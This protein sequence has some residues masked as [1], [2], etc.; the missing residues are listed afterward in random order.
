VIVEFMDDQ[1]D[2]FGVEP[3]CTVLQM[4]PSYYAAK[5]RPVRTSRSSPNGSVTPLRRSRSTCTRMCRPDS[6]LVPRRLLRRW[7][8]PL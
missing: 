6:K 7:S 3:I 2:E 1:R 4:A 5:T 8:T